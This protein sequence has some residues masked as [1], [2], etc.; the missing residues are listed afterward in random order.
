VDDALATTFAIFPT[1]LDESRF[2]ADRLE[3]FSN[4][5]RPLVDELKPV[6]DNLGPT[7]HDLGALSPDLINLFQRLPRVI[8]AA[9][10][11]LP[12]AGRFLRGARPV[13]EALHPFLQELNPI[14]SFVNQDQQALATFISQA[15]A[16]LNYRISNQPNTHYLPQFGVIGSHS[17]SLQ[18][19]VPTWLRANAYIA[20]NNRDRQIP[21][22]TIESFSCKNTGL[23]GLGT[24]RNPSDATDAG[25]ELP[26]CFTQPKFLYYNQFYP[27]LG[28][29]QVIKKPPPTNSLRGYWPANPNT[30]P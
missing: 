8:A 15:A 12:Q 30:H 16:A 5:T 27:F 10:R 23:P 19:T 14:L 18:Q 4:N 2:T 7:V 20:G 26:P 29:G 11:T 6:A 25:D 17:L 1:F 9:P 24:K 21:L 28:K 3:R 22:G 13:V